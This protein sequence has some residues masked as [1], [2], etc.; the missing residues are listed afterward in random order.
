MDPS[1]DGP[2]ES[3]NRFVQAIILVDD[4]PTARRSM[5]RLGLA[6]AEGGRHPGRGTANLIVPFGDQ[7]LE[8]LAVVDENEA[9]ASAQGRPVLAALNRHGPGLARWSVEAADIDATAARLGH[10]VERR[11]RDRPDGVTV[12]W[13]A[14]GVDAAWDEPWRCAFMAWD[15]PASHPARAALSHPNG[16]SGFESLEVD[17]PDGS[18]A[19]DWLGGVVPDGVT[20]GAG[21][22]PGPR[23]LAIATPSGPVVVAGK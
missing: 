18:A 5:E 17:V 1:S 4:L 8:L 15:D 14:V 12:R 22:A 9:A 2:A 13:R 16:A 20:L 19:L 10:P 6:V 23:R 7:Y 21:S 11:Q 3:G